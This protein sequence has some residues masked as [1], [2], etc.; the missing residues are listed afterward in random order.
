M[1]I[2]L[3]IPPFIQLNTPYTSITSLT[4]FLKERQ[5]AAT[6]RD[7][8]LDL[9]LSI[10][11]R[12]GLQMLFDN[13]Q[14]SE[15][16]LSENALFILEN[17]DLYITTIDSIIKFLQNED[18]TLATRICTR[19]MLPEASRFMQFDD[20]DESFGYM[21]IV[22]KAKHLATLYLEDIA[23]FIK[24]AIDSEYGMSRYA[25]SLALSAESF[26]SLYEKL[27]SKPSIIDN[28]MLDIF[29]DYLQQTKPRIIG[30]SIPFPG[31]VYMAL[32]CK[33]YK[34]KV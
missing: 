17:K 28:L 8:S 26:D 30:I 20:V 11:S 22:D 3:I 29:D 5:F 10:H 2:L 14:S 7:L 31:N 9:F 25:E 1:D 15:S 13:A 18:P 24:E 32:R 27:C 16:E 12:N 23:D 34:R 33:K 21:G 6:Q 4:G 19:N